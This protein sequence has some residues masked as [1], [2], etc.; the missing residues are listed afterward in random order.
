MLYTKMA[1]MKIWKY[2]IQLLKKLSKLPWCRFYINFLIQSEN[3][4]L[5]IFSETVKILQRMSEKW[6]SFLKTQ[7]F[8]ITSK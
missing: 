3:S 2:N 1:K 6:K 5:E 8:H 4:C 7:K